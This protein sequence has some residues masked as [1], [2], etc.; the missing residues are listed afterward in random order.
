FYRINY[1]ETN[2]KLITEFLNT[3]DINHIHV[4]NRAQLIDDA[5]TLA[6]TGKLNYNIPLFLST[7]MEREVEW[8]PISAFSKALLLLNKMLAAQPE[9][10]LFENYVN[11][12]LSGAYGHL[13]FLEGP[14]D[15]HS[16]KLIRISVLNWLCKVG[17]QECRTKSLNQVRA[18]KANNQ[19]DITPNL[20]TPVFCGAMRIGNSEDWEFLYQKF[21]KA[22]N[23]KQKFQLLIGLSCSENK[24]ILNRFLDKVLEDNSTLTFIERYSIFTSVSSAGNIGLNTVFDY[25]DEHL[26]SLKT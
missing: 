16:G 6:D 25:I 18:W 2:W 22:V 4:L 19:S 5:F 12:S 11:K 14:H 8:A 17:H 7:Y 13:G 9:Y 10:N 3:H 20:E 23:R 1:D 26:E 21:I 24:N 15:Q